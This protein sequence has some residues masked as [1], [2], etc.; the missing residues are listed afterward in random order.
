MGRMMSEW[1]YQLQ[2][3]TKEKGIN[4]LGRIFGS[5]SVVIFITGGGL[6]FNVFVMWLVEMCVVLYTK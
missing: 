2:L 6:M 5:L 3:R 1:R 4:N